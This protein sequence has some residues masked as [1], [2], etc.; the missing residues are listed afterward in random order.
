MVDTW[1]QSTEEID[2]SGESLQKNQKSKDS[3]SQEVLMKELTQEVLEYARLKN[4]SPDDV[5]WRLAD[6]FRMHLHKKGW[7]YGE[8]M[9]TIA[10]S[11][12]EKQLERKHIKH[13]K[14]DMFW[15]TAENVYVN[16]MKR[17]FKLKN[18]IAF[19]ELQVE[20]FADQ[21]WN[22]LWI[23]EKNNFLEFLRASWFIWFDG[24][25]NFDLYTELCGKDTSPT[26]IQDIFQKRKSYNPLHL[27]RL[28][29]EFYWN[30]EK[31]SVEWFDRLRESSQ[32]PIF[33]ILSKF[34]SKWLYHKDAVE[35]SSR[36]W[37][38]WRKSKSSIKEDTTF[39]KDQHLRGKVW[40]A[41]KVAWVSAL[42]Q[43]FR[44]TNFQSQVKKSLRT[45]SKDHEEWQIQDQI[46]AENELYKIDV[47]A[48]D[49]ISTIQRL[50]DG[51]WST[52]VEQTLIHEFDGLREKDEE[53]KTALH[54]DWINDALFSSYPYSDFENQSESWSM[55]RKLNTIRAA[56][57]TDWKKP[58]DIIRYKD[59]T[60]IEVVDDS[61]YTKI[62]KAAMQE[63]LHRVAT[64]DSSFRWLF[65]RRNSM[66]AQ[67]WFHWSELSLSDLDGNSPK[68]FPA[69][70]WIDQDALNTRQTDFSNWQ[71]EKA[72][73]TY[74]KSWF[75]EIINFWNL[76]EFNPERKSEQTK[77]ETWQIYKQFMKDRYDPNKLEV[78]LPWVWTIVTFTHKSWRLQSDEHGNKIKSLEDF[79]LWW[80]R[81]HSVYEPYFLVDIKTSD[82]H[83][84]KILHDSFQFYK[85][86]DNLIWWN[87]IFDQDSD[88]A[89][90]NMFFMSYLLAKTQKQEHEKK[91]NED[92]KDKMRPWYEKKID[93][94]ERQ[95]KNP[96]EWVIEKI[97]DSREKRYRKKNPPPTRKDGKLEQRKLDAYEWII[98]EARNQERSNIK[99][100][101]LAWVEGWEIV[102]RKEHLIERLESK[103]KTYRGIDIKLDIQMSPD[104]REQMIRATYG[105]EYPLLRTEFMQFDEFFEDPN[106]LLSTISD[107]ADRL[108]I[109]T[110]NKEKTDL[111]K[112]EYRREVAWMERHE[113]THRL[114]MYFDV[115]ELH[116]QETNGT[117]VI[118]TEEELC[119][120]AEK[121]FW[122]NLNANYVD[123][124]IVSFKRESNG[125]QEWEI[126]EL[127]LRTINSD[128]S[129]ELNK[130][131]NHWSSDSYFSNAPSTMK[132]YATQGDTDRFKL[133][134]YD[135]DGIEDSTVRSVARELIDSG[136]YD[137]I[138]DLLKTVYEATTPEARAAVLRAV[139]P[140]QQTITQLNDNAKWLT[141]DTEKFV[142][143]VEKAV[144]DPNNV[145]APA[146]ADLTIAETGRRMRGI[147]NQ[148]DVTINEVITQ[149]DRLRSSWQ[150]AS[151]INPQID[152][153]RD[154]EN[155]LRNARDRYS[156]L[157][158]TFEQWQAA[159][160]WNARQILD[161]LDAW[162][163][164]SQEA[165]NSVN[166][167]WRNVTNTPN[168]EEEAKTLDAMRKEAQKAPEDENQPD[169]AEN[170]REY[171]ASIF[172]D[173]K[174]DS[175]IEYN[176][177]DGVFTWWNWPNEWVLLYFRT[178]T[179]N[180]PGH[181][182]SWMK[183]RI[184][185]HWWDSYYIELDDGT[186]WTPPS[187]ESISRDINWD[188]LKQLV[189]S[190]RGEVYKARETTDFNDAAWYLQDGI[191]TLNWW[192]VS[193]S[194][195]TRYFVDPSQ[196]E[197]TWEVWF[198]RKTWDLKYLWHYRDDE[199]FDFYKIE[200]NWNNVTVTSLD[201][202]KPFTSTMDRTSLAFFVKDK[203]LTP[204]NEQEYQNLI[205]K[206]K[207]P[208]DEPKW[209]WSDSLLS[210]SAVIAAFKKF[211]ESFKHYF[212]EREKYQSAK[213]Y[214]QLAERMPEIYWL[215]TNDVKADALAELDSEIWKV[216]N[217][218]KDRLWR[219]DG[220]WSWVHKKQAAIRIDR[221]IF[222]NIRTDERYR[223]KAAW[224]LLYALDQGNMYYR[225]LS[226]YKH[227]WLW[228]EAL[229]GKN[230]HATFMKQRKQFHDKLRNF[231]YEDEEA[232]NDLI[233]FEIQYIS[234][235]TTSSNMLHLYGSKF[236]KAVESF[237]ENEGN[238]IERQKEW[239]WKK[240]SYFETYKTIRWKIEKQEPGWIV[241]WIELLLEWAETWQ[242]YRM[243]YSL[244]IQWYTSGVIP[245]VLGNKWKG[246]LKQLGRTYGI[247]MLIM[248]KDIH[249][250]RRVTYLIDNIAT[251]AWIQSFSWF[252]TEKE[253]LPYRVEDYHIHNFS[254]L[255]PWQGRNYDGTD[256]KPN[257]RHVKT[258]KHTEKRMGEHADTII[259]ALNFKND[260]YFQALWAA[261][262]DTKR[263]LQIYYNQKVHD[264]QTSVD[265]WYSKDSFKQWESPHYSNWILNLWY[266]TFKWAMR[267]T[268]W[269]GWRQ[270]LRND[271]AIDMWKKLRSNVEWINS[272]IWW[273]KVSGDWTANPSAK[274]ML[275]FI[276]KKFFTYFGT[277]MDD[278][279][280]KNV[281]SLLLGT[282]SRVQDVT[283]D[284][285]GKE[286]WSEEFGMRKYLE[287]IIL[288]GNGIRNIAVMKEWVGAFIKLFEDHRGLLSEY[289]RFGRWTPW[290]QLTDPYP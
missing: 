18:Q 32:L 213:L 247:P 115:H 168:V 93:R 218:H 109:A 198:E 197:K 39:K 244:I 151:Y 161:D 79:S 253:W 49:G 88:A 107:P 105:K 281:T 252:V 216:I 286:T 103:V 189:W 246:K 2:E 6:W 156:W 134:E 100:N 215:Y 182:T 204:H 52:W 137:D 269:W 186:E 191:W 205:K 172:N 22:E 146:N 219:N 227:T 74:K 121:D 275:H 97:L 48:D 206:H 91:R 271:V 25:G 225:E 255:L 29:E 290:P 232:F 127:N 177:R 265:V 282:R 128:L 118:L 239:I 149:I 237:T 249:A 175:S 35:W 8:L 90:L 188:D 201:P 69:W 71:I 241:W 248:A 86:K 288:D 226:H 176:P 228:V 272:S 195:W 160:E 66:N 155:W 133:L 85:L 190:F 289:S 250:Q 234:E 75:D 81:S 113:E 101:M 122:T 102:F 72:L 193:G 138:D 98:E 220:D 70:S 3:L 202:E 9:T 235:Y 150:P 142:E 200:N 266:S 169:E 73:Q 15:M 54:Q 280:K 264:G 164:V 57:D 211:P 278:A 166:Q 11:L 42:K 267:D 89:K 43:K 50:I 144:K 116:T 277:D 14:I 187:R 83:I 167:A 170:P 180:L 207:P 77:E 181:G 53:R 196:N 108:K 152:K 46:W 214:A 126:I 243:L 287:K 45:S 30:H 157:A 223:H 106:A 58:W 276:V 217:G 119:R 262:W 274:Y 114:L 209:K 131:I 153:L 20:T 60:T 135:Q 12:W 84:I 17:L 233:M 158:D 68:K 59:G 117:T 123:R 24:H 245:Y 124:N 270:E 55:W 208:K 65:D 285:D 259:D 183:A 41:A 222:K 256:Y 185:P 210:I 7:T 28:V 178:W 141:S 33:T 140:L 64:Q 273:Y 125:K 34:S 26:S 47:T 1:D 61:L 258:V 242:H 5:M 96:D 36:E 104:G 76:S 165:L 230:H 263:D 147:Q 110:L 129:D 67:A 99:K 44:L 192:E 257:S 87:I 13:I 254:A 62:K 82:P 94:H 38:E 136:A 163:R 224:Y 148:F 111:L 283:Y 92:F 203:K 229:L 238:D 112:Y 132:H 173:L 174:G 40:E 251:Q 21:L 184:V 179:S 279:T 23:T 240:W 139:E 145:V 260:Y 10:T 143:R 19:V 261:T 16:R 4:A 27:K 37:Y 95:I 120:I 194:A 80:E 159:V 130:K 284:R 221:E 63:Y 78:S 154:I 171:F 236:G 56:S 199:K 268:R 31:S 212:D 51:L 231:W 162:T